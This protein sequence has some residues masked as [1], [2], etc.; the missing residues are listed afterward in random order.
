M[1]VKFS[2]AGGRPGAGLATGVLATVGMR[3]NQWAPHQTNACFRLGGPFAG[4][5]RWDAHF[6][7]PRLAWTEKFRED[8]G[9]L[10]PR[11]AVFSAA[12][13]PTDGGARG[14]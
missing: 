7:E 11:P 9:R 12:R 10:G 8:G 13:R 4:R 14:D 6:Y 2:R 1:K 5:W 3:W